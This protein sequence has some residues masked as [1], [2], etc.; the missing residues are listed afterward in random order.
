MGYGDKKKGM[1]NGCEQSVYSVNRK[2]CSMSTQ[3]VHAVKV[4]QQN[5]YKKKHKERTTDTTNKRRVGNDGVSRTSE[6][7]LSS[8]ADGQPVIHLNAYT[9]HG[10]KDVQKSTKHS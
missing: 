8:K 3:T 6:E 9:Q 5:T 2:N 1:F 10:V 7:W 4:A